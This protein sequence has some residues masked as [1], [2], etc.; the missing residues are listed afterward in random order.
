MILIKFFKFESQ[1]PLLTTGKISISFL[2]LNT[3]KTYVKKYICLYLNVY[4]NIN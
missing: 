2:S 1:F 4:L 3:R